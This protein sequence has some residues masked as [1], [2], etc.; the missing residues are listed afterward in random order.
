LQ[1]D[2]DG[3]LATLLQYVNE[4][5]EGCGQ[6]SPAQGRGNCMTQ[7]LEDA[8]Q[9]AE[10]VRA[11]MKRVHAADDRSL[12]PLPG[13]PEPRHAGLPRAA[14]HARGIMLI[15]RDEKKALTGR[16]RE[17][18]RLI[19]EGYSSK[20]GAIR[21]NI[22]FRTFD[23]HRLEIKRKLGAR[24][25]ADLVRQALLQPNLQ[26]IVPLSAGPRPDQDI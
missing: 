16:E 3:P 15:S 4:I 9:Q 11:M 25:T 26:R 19:C 23:C 20:Q 5:K 12:E 6:S 14:A 1:G 17:V 22:S 13:Q 21:M 18:L 8:L 24:N 7:L 2:L 10:R